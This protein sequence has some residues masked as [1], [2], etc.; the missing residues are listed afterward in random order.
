MKT[1]TSS[2]CSTI[3]TLAGEIMDNEQ[4]ITQ[5]DL[6]ENVAVSVSTEELDFYEG[7][8]FL[9]A[10]WEVDN[11][12]PSEA[13]LLAEA[14]ENELWILSTEAHSSLFS[15]QR[16]PGHR[17][18]PHGS[19]VRRPDTVDPVIAWEERLQQ[20]EHELWLKLYGEVELLQR[21]PV[22]TGR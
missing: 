18:E 21:D 14:Q 16:V 1:A 13:E 15:N 4:P 10:G 19:W 20:A 7:L 3:E 12:S 22:D 9:V 11:P 17:D 6:F 5:D 8:E 2:I